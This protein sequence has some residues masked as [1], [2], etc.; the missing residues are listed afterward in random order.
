MSVTRSALMLHLQNPP[1][2]YHFF[3]HFLKPTFPS[4]FKPRPFSLT[5]STRP[6]VSAVASSS[7]SQ[8]SNA[9]DTFFAEQNV[10][11]T[12]LGLSDTISKAL[13]DIGLNRP[14]LVQVVP[15]LRFIVFACFHVAPFVNP[16]SLRGFVGN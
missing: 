5:S 16:C 12:S 3:S 6:F 9:R 2:R 13:S 8:A 10:S 4:L 7:S 1:I 15:S 11:W 14:S